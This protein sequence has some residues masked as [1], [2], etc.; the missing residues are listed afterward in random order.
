M[1]TYSILS[2]S[3]KEKQILIWGLN[4][5]IFPL[6]QKPRTSALF[7]HLEKAKGGRLSKRL[8]HNEAKFPASWPSS[9]GKQGRRRG[10]E[11]ST[12]V[13]VYQ[14]PY[15]TR[16]RPDTNEP[17]PQDAACGLTPQLPSEMEQGHKCLL[18]LA[19]SFLSAAMLPT[20]TKDVL[21]ERCPA[22]PTLSQ[23]AAPL[24]DA[25]G[26]LPHRSE[27]PAGRCPLSTNPPALHRRLH[28]GQNAHETPAVHQQLSFVFSDPFP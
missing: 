7:A 2:S 24:L 9:Q 17:V 3:E 14:G 19:R 21:K 18:Y 5:L 13:T 16:S 8:L 25:R 6:K 26:P 22:L 27:Q 10:G 20:G 28:L 15:T 1:K 23:Q 12:L 11:H 4:L